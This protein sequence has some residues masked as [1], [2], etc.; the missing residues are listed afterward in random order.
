L[1]Y[2]FRN[3]FFLRG[4]VKRTIGQKLFGKDETS[5]EDF[6]LGAGFAIE[7]ASLTRVSADYAYARFG[8]LGGVH[9][10]SLLF[11]Y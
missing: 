1:E 2:A 3:T 6:T 7:L 4:G 9:R 8:D 5:T 10:F 11:T